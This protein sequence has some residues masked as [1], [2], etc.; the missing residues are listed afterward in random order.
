VGGGGRRDLHR[1]SVAKFIV[2]GVKSGRP[3]CTE[4]ECCM[5]GGRKECIQNFV[6]ENS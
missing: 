6:G 5:N 2:R 3:L 4:N 1:S